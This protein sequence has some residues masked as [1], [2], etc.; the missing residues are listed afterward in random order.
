MH[1]DHE[2]ELKRKIPRGVPPS[3][4]ADDTTIAMRTPTNRQAAVELKKILHDLE[5]VTGL[6]VNP[7]KSEILLLYDKPTEEQKKILSDFGT[8]KE[9]V[10]HLGVTISHDYAQGRKLTYEAGKTAMKKAA[11]KISSGILSTN[12]ILKSQ[13][14]NVVVSSINNHRFRVYPQQLLK[15]KKFGQ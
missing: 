11:I 12:L 9:N 4:F 7:T 15:S 13:A 2:L 8:I 3:A 5:D 1:P 10:T 6:K 14:V